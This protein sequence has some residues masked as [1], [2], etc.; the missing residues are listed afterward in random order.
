MDIRTAQLNPGSL[1]GSFTLQER[2]GL[3]GFAEVWRA[4]TPEK[5]APIA[6]KIMRAKGLKDY[7]RFR[8]EAEVQQ[9][10]QHPNIVQVHGLH[11]V[12][13]YALIELEFVQGPTLL[14]WLTRQRPT[15]AQ[16]DRWIGQLLDGLE[17][18][19][20]QGVIHRDIKPG[21]V[22]ID[23]SGEALTAKLA[24]FGIARQQA[25][26]HS[27]ITQ[28]GIT[29]GTP[30]YMAPEQIRQTGD[31]DI[32]VDL[33]ALG[34]LAYRLLTGRPAFGGGSQFDVLTRTCMGDYRP[35]Q[36]VN[37]ALPERYAK[38]IDAALSIERN[39]RPAD[40]NA[41]REMWQGKAQPVFMSTGPGSTETVEGF[42]P[43]PVTTNQ[44][45][46][47]NRRL[48]RDRF[49]GRNREFGQLLR[50]LTDHTTRIITLKGPGGV[51]KTRLAD[52]C[53]STLSEAE[54][55]GGIWRCNLTAAQKIEELVEALRAVFDLRLPGENSLET[56][57]RAI[58]KRGPC[59]LLLDN[60]EQILEPAATVIESLM[61]MAPALHVL[62][63]SRIALGIRSETVIELSSVETLDAIELFIDRAQTARPNF[64]PTAHQRQIIQAIVQRLD[65]LP[66]AI[67]LA[68][69]RLRM[70]SLDQLNQQLTTGHQILRRSRRGEDARHNSLRQAIDWSWALL[71]PWE[72]LA[73]AQCSV[74]RG[75]FTLDAI[76][77]VLCLD[78]FS[79]SPWAID[80]IE[81]LVDQS[82][83]RLERGADGV[84]RFD[85]YT[86]IRDYAAHQLQ[87][88][89]S[90]Q[91]PNGLSLTGPKAKQDQQVR[92]AGYYS[93][94]GEEDYITRMRGPMGPPL[95]K[96]MARELPNFLAAQAFT[97]A[98]PGPDL[99]P[100]RA[101]T[102]LIAARVLQR[103]G[104]T[105]QAVSLMEK[106]WEAQHIR[107]DLRAQLAANLGVFY[108]QIGQLER[109][110]M[111]LKQSLN[112]ISPHGRPNL[113]A[114]LLQHLGNMSRQQG[115][116]KQARVH[117]E[118][119]LELA[120]TANL[121]AIAGQL[122]GDLGTVALVEHDLESAR[123]LLEQSIQQLMSCGQFD[124]ANVCRGNLAHLA[125][126]QGRLEDAFEL[127][128]QCVTVAQRRRN[129]RQEMYMLGHLGH[130]AL[131]IGQLDTAETRIRQAIKL[132][133][134]MGD[135][136]RGGIFLCG[137][138]EIE[139][140]R[141]N[142]TEAKRLLLEAAQL[143]EGL[144][145]SASSSAQRLLALLAAREK[146]ETESHFH[147]SAAEDW[148]NKAGPIVEL[149]LSF[150]QV[151][152]ALA[153]QQPNEA[154]RAVQQLQ[155]TIQDSPQPPTPQMKERYESLKEQLARLSES[156]NFGR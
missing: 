72:Q 40:A 65:S 70:L 74:F 123:H 94:F 35:I 31:I 107:S 32:R 99:D 89:G 14:Q 33:F 78:A 27:E 69:S 34:A 5:K 60:L 54:W 140:K 28:Q 127:L 137:L 106:A 114:R 9:R 2:V 81:S 124:G 4:T 49:H 62:T 64:N 6:L 108:R 130:A 7:I 141:Q 110:A 112:E 52:E 76:E 133:E 46:Q 104:Q 135:Q 88:D 3:G 30:G 118:R 131:A 148:G 53:L 145:P 86:A 58:Q 39:Q 85:L 45:V 24:D 63:T 29:I 68:A 23:G 84:Q 44:S 26:P 18:A 22:L 97:C 149:E 57:G 116:P 77:D 155:K 146:Q 42:V 87:T 36:Q 139:L 136:R 132:N 79:D 11:L 100:V 66:L 119:A 43:R 73:L 111:I 129:K 154:E 61:D 50:R 98:N 8:Q 92:H 82:M 152:I 134:G 10:L 125:T 13:G 103:T 25:T 48:H 20:E 1:V 142:H 15:E 91:D 143:V 156:T 90:V 67:E 105:R 96:T 113:Q 71:Q 41:F 121:T 17:S 47:T 115:D 51:G 153:L 55:T 16:S 56:L 93:Q 80:V 151:E 126:R 122:L 120:N 128:Q 101:R 150:T 147:F 75:G 38:T 12:D 102:G 95:V 109:A 144:D 83:L 19:H 59:V 37:P 21:N 138:G 117:L